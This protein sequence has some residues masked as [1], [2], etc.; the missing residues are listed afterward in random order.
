M[1]L[2]AL[3]TIDDAATRCIILAEI[4][5]LCQRRYTTDALKRHLDMFEVDCGRAARQ[6]LE[7]GFEEY[8]LTM[9]TMRGL[10]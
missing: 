5:N 4:Q 3:E 9:M 8:V 10:R 7:K 2:K 1:Q 6:A